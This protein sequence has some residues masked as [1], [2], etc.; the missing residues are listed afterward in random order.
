MCSR[1]QGSGERE[2]DQE[3]VFIFSLQGHIVSRVDAVHGEVYKGNGVDV[4]SLL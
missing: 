2:Q 3:N 4:R 1:M